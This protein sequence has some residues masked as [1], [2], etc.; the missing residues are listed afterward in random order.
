MKVQALVAVTAQLKV[1]KLCTPVFAIPQPPV[2]PSH[3]SAK[4]LSKA[5]PSQSLASHYLASFHQRL[6]ILSLGA[7][8]LNSHVKGSAPSVWE[9]RLDRHRGKTEL[10]T[11]IH[12]PA[13]LQTERSQ[14]LSELFLPC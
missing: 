14:Q 9:H 2:P 5:F 4:Y 11:N 13:T 1:L 12:K 6:V 7:S 10:L 8:N 3:Y